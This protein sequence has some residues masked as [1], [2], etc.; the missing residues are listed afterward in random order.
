MQALKELT[1]LLQKYNI[2]PLGQYSAVDKNSKLQEFYEGVLKNAFKTDADASAALYEGEVTSSKYRKLKSDLW[3]RLLESVPLINLDQNQASD[4]QKAYYNCHKEWLTV[5]LLMGQNANTAAM[6]LATRLLRQAEKFEFTLLCMDIAAY[7]RIQYAL[8]ESND[9]KFLKANE[10]FTRFKEIYDAESLAEELYTQLTAS[11]VNNRS[12]QSKVNEKAVAYYDQ[13]KEKLDQYATYRLH[14]YGNLLSM[15]RFTS[16]NDYPKVLENCDKAIAF[17]KSK[18]YEARGPLQIFYYQRLVCNIQLR[19]FEAGKES[20][21]YCMELMEEGGFNWFKYM[22][23]YFQLSMHTGRYEEG[24]RILHSTL[25]NSRFEF[26]PDNA[27]EIWRIY[28]SYVYYLGLLDK[29][30]LPSGYVFKLAKFVN[31]TPIFSRDKSGLNISIIVIRFLILLQERKYDKVLDEVE[32]ID[33]YTYRHLRGKNTRRSYL[34][35]RLLIQIPLGAFD[36]G[37]IYDKAQRYL[38]RLKALPLNT[39]NQ[40]HE[41]EV[42]PYEDLWQFALGSL[43]TTNIK[44]K[45]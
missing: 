2:H 30:K 27:K 43:N 24:A 28:E 5:R 12:A 10:Q 9:Q 36:K 26:L 16:L 20:A 18:P 17:F 4:Y 41:I 19:Q 35:I 31:E 25:K 13:V 44:R 21:Q 15:I 37:L 7:L 34:F 38:K 45:K 6:K 42:L 29:V 22:E 11:Y 32:T 33:R 40:T 1:L 39:A 14:L 8:R 3:D 23:L